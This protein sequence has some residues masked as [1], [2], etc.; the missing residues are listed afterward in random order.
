MEALG[1]WVRSRP[2]RAPARAALGLGALAAVAAVVVGPL[3]G[4]LVVAAG[5]A[6][7]LPGLAWMKS[8]RH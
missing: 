6:L 3:A 4:L 2:G 5:A 8:Q 1:W 7:V